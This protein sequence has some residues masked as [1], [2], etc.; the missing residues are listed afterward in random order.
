M[1]FCFHL[2][3]TAEAHYV[4]SRSLSTFRRLDLLDFTA[5]VIAIE[6]LAR[7]IHPDSRAQG[8]RVAVQRRHQ[9]S[10]S[11]LASPAHCNAPVFSS[12]PRNTH[13]PRS[14][15]PVSIACAGLGLASRLSTSGLHNPRASSPEFDDEYD[16]GRGSDDDSGE[17]S[18][19]QYY[20]S[21]GAGGMCEGVEVKAAMD[22]VAGASRSNGSARIGRLA[23][24]HEP[25]VAVRGGR[26]IARERGAAGVQG[27]RIVPASSLI[28]HSASAV[29]RCVFCFQVDC[30][31][32]LRLPAA[33]QCMSVTTGICTVGYRH[34]SLLCVVCG[35][36]S[37]IPFLYHRL[38]RCAGILPVS[39][40]SRHHTSG[41]TVLEDARAH[42]LVP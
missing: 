40:S 12:P 39:S 25:H 30:L 6:Q 7:A 13:A 20:A 32:D 41:P 26:Y 27:R 34:P 5:V 28:E 14:V 4:C 16:F 17:Y 42:T 38:P 2:F 35:T 9:H 8:G 23:T 22:G 1:I 18:P 31:D 29:E 33:I 21:A 10:L 36:R 37:A 11:M 3:P 15:V 19:G 24:L